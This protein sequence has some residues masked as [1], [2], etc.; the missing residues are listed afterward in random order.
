MKTYKL[1]IAAVIFILLT[2]IKLA[3]P[4]QIELMREQVSEQIDRDI[5]Y[6]NMATKLVSTFEKY[7]DIW[8]M[9]EQIDPEPSP[10]IASTPE[11]SPSPELTPEPEIIEAKE[12]VSVFA[13]STS[14][15]PFEYTAPSTA[16]IGSG[17][18]ERIHPVD[19][20]NKFHYGVDYSA[21]YGEDIL[22]FAAGQVISSS[23]CEGYGYYIIIEHDETYKTLYAHCSELLVEAGES[24]VLGQC[25][26][27]VGATGL[28]TG[29]HLHFEVH[30]NDICI[31]PELFI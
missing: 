22:A 9:P 21:Q 1:I 4:E 23:Y 13:E 27:K 3:V 25:I 12:V 30:E 8:Q 19:G 31:D 16:E 14:P 6:K 29:P 20:I 11:P 5:D 2:A 18:G 15:L 10:E 26:A 24:V 28:A 7:S 17:F